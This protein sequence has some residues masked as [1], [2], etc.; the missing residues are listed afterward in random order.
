MIR[1]GINPG[2]ILAVTFTKKAA[3]EMKERLRELVGERLSERLTVMTL[4]AFCS[5]CLRRYGDNN[6]KS[7]SIFDDTEARSLIKRILDERS[8]MNTNYNGHEEDDTSPSKLLTAIS[9][10]KR[11]GLANENKLIFYGS[12]PLYMLACE[13]LPLYQES[14]RLSNAKDLTI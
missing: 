9:N 11:A 3:I 12:N 7:Y 1:S 14:L 8:S 6:S 2:Q 5:Q 4:H 13:I 10:L